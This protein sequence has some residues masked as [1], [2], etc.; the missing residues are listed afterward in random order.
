MR[1]NEKYIEMTGET[2]YC[3]LMYV[4]TMKAK[5]GK[6]LYLRHIKDI[7]K[8]N[9]EITEICKWVTDRNE[10]TYFETEKKAREYAENYFKNFKN[11]EITEFEYIY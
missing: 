11:W 2:L 9:G 5:S 4:I 6:T 7:Y 3:D 8:R 1:I 10:S